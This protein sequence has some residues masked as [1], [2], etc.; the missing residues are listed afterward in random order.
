[1]TI[2]GYLGLVLFVGLIVV[3]VVF[4]SEIG[5]LFKPLV[6]G[7][8]ALTNPRP[9]RVADCPTGY[10]NNGATCGINADSKSSSAEKGP[11]VVAS[12]PPGYK[13]MGLTCFR[14]YNSFTTDSFNC[15]GQDCT[16]RCTNA[17][18]SDGDSWPCKKDALG[19][20]IYPSCT[21][22]AKKKGLAFADEYHSGGAFCAL[23]AKTL[24][25]GNASMVCP[26][27]YPKKSGGFCYIDC[28]KKYG[29]GYY[30]NGTSCWHDTDTKSM[31]SMTCK[32]GEVK[33]GARCYKPCPTG[34]KPD[35]ITG[36][37]CV[38]A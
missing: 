7:I 33:I 36:I 22:Q 32:S 27:D 29:P 13:N 34:K 30:N 23:D 35:S 21:S 18:K 28:E 14:D 4:S 25:S 1:M 15:V 37:T 2:G 8:T 17:Y 31:S 20:R 6:D 5:A 19:A 11:Y 26:S 38:N 9:S 12:C 10:T 24:P 3:C 16:G